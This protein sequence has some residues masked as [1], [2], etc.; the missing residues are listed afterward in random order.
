MIK[1]LALVQGLSGNLTCSILETTLFKFIFVFL[2]DVLWD[3]AVFQRFY[4]D[5]AVASVARNLAA[6]LLRLCLLHGSKSPAS[7]RREIKRVICPELHLTS[8]IEECTLIY[9]LRSKVV[10][11]SKKQWRFLSC[12][13]FNTI[14]PYRESGQVHR[15]IRYILFGILLLLVKLTLIITIAA[16]TAPFITILAA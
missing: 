1:F 10:I 2:K 16:I 8:F 5:N 12:L 3:F 13:T 14:I 15:A 9:C 6:L 11:I 4:L 7:S